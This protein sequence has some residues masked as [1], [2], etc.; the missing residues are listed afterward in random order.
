MFKN[1]KSILLS[2]L[3]VVLVAAL[4]VGAYFL[5]DFLKPEVQEGSKTVTVTVTR[6]GQTLQ[7]KNYKTDAEYLEGVLRENNIAEFSSGQ[8]G[9][10]I[11]S[12]CG[13]KADSSSEFWAIYLNGEMTMYGASEQPVKDGEIYELRLEKFW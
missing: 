4:A 13:I 2:V 12:A 6:D 1:K 10:Y 3:A 8:Y 11:E 7:N 9:V 5:Y